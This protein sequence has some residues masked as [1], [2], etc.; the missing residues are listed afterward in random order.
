M[1]PGALVFK[2]GLFPRWG[3][4]IAHDVEEGKFLLLMTASK[5]GIPTKLYSVDADAVT[6]SWRFFD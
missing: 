6:E 3:I 4:V 5:D 1:V 2:R